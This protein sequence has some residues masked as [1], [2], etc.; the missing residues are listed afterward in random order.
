MAKL[1][2]KQIQDLARSII[3]ANPGGIRYSA[4]I[5]DRIAS[6][7]PETPKNTIAGAIGKLDNLARLFLQN[8]NADGAQKSEYRREDITERQPP[9]RQPCLHRRSSDFGSKL[10]RPVRSEEV[11]M[12]SQQFQMHFQ[13]LFPPRIRKA[14]TTQ[15]GRALPDSQVQSFDVGFNWR[16]SSELRHTSSQRHAA[17]NRAFRCTLTTRLFLRFLRT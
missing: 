1:T 2:I 6:Q 7:H 10:Q 11:V 15:V 5:N 4:L 12:A 3:A 8:E 13:S 9:F 17:P 16:E 14:P